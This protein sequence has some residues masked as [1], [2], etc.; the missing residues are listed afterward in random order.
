MRSSDLRPMYRSMVKAMDT[1]IGRLRDSLDGIGALDNT[2][3]IF[4]SDNGTP[5]AAAG[6]PNYVSPGCPRSKGT[7]YEGGVNVPLII[8]GPSVTASGSIDALVHLVDLYPTI[9]DLCTIP[10]ASLPSDIDGL[11]LAPLLSGATTTPRFLFT[12]TGIVELPQFSVDTERPILGGLQPGFSAVRD[13][14]YKLIR[15]EGVPQ[16]ACLPTEGASLEIFF[17]LLTSPNENVSSPR[18]GPRYTAL[19]DYLTMMRQ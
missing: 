11:T 12:D 17:D 13:D 18:Q 16:G 14:R 19:A 8:S 2:D 9:A 1:E 4:T 10:P 15:Y 7:P 6:P 3:V 5:A